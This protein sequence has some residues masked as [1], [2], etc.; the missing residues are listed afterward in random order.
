MGLL[1][2]RVRTP[3]QA[4]E[5]P[6]T[7]FRNCRG[8]SILARGKMQVAKRRPRKLLRWRGYGI[9]QIAR[10]SRADKFAVWEQSG[11][12]AGRARGAART[13]NVN[14]SCTTR[15]MTRSPAP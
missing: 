1:L 5:S 12:W 13:L 2:L 4:Q 7:H 3:G 15:P 10:F 14:G 11:L 9:S 6:G 8:Y